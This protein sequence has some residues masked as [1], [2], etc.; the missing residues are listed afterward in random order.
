MKLTDPADL[1]VLVDML[2][3]GKSTG[4][5]TLP[6]WAADRIATILLSLPGRAGRPRREE[7]ALPDLS[8]GKSLKATAREI[9]EAAGLKESSIRRRLQEKQARNRAKKTALR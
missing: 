3:N 1:V 9:A 5:I 2:G 6:Y 4:P 8:C 7:H